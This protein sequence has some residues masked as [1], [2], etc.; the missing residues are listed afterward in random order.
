MDENTSVLVEMRVK[1]KIIHIFL[2]IHYDVDDT[3]AQDNCEKMSSFLVCSG[4]HISTKEV[5]QKHYQC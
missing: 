3:K 4:S 5:S 1:S 2:L